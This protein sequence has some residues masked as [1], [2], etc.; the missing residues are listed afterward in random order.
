MGGYVA[1]VMPPVGP[2]TLAR[3]CRGSVGGRLWVDPGL[4]LNHASVGSIV[5]VKPLLVN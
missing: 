3:A 5:T 2:R 1:R 4:A